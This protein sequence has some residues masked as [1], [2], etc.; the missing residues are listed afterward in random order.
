MDIQ[1][2]IDE[3]R[4]VVESLLGKPPVPFEREDIESIPDQSGIYSFYIPSTQEFLYA[5][6]SD[7]GLKSRMK[8][9][10]AGSAS[11]ENSLMK[12]EDFESKYHIRKWMESITVVQYL[13]S[14]EFDMDIK[15]AENFVIGVLRPKLN[16]T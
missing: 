9:H 12:T 16:K 15:W 11:L 10:W 14:D 3:G 6:K 13:T 7:R 8:D 1:E 5:G 4:A 2:R